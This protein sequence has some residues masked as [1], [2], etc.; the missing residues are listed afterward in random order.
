MTLKGKGQMEKFQ[1]DFSNY[2]KYL[3]VYFYFFPF[4]DLGYPQEKG[5][6]ILFRHQ[7]LL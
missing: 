3:Y 6:K 7:K 2:S 5:G 1:Y 4:L